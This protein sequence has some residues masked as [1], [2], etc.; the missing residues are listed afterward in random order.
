MA[1]RFGIWLFQQGRTKLREKGRRG[2]R[3]TDRD[4][5]KKHNKGLDKPVS[6][7]IVVVRT[8]RI[9][10]I[11]LE[12]KLI[13]ERRGKTR[14]LAVCLSVFSFLLLAAPSVKVLLFVSVSC[15]SSIDFVTF[16]T[17]HCYNGVQYCIRNE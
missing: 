13:E 11:A 17:L 15:T 12:Q 14:A 7:F 9:L 2:E 8:Y 16:T 1:P 6:Y 4:T 5:Q 3:E 10:V